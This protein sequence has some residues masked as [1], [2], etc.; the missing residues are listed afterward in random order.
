LWD[1]GLTLISKFELHLQGS[2]QLDW[3]EILDS[4]DPNDDRNVAH[5]EVQ[6]QNLLTNIFAKGKWTNM[7]NCIHCSKKPK[8]MTTSQVFACLCHMIAITQQLPNAPQELFTI[9]EQ[10]RILLQMFCIN[11]VMN[12]SNAGPTTATKTMQSIKRYMSKQEALD[13]PTKQ[14]KMKLSSNKVSNTSN[15]QGNS[16]RQNS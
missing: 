10:K 15:N 7:A 14:E 11:W 1:D 9:N 6:V 3:Q 8:S 16:T 13:L 5:F 12:I 4:T 2:F